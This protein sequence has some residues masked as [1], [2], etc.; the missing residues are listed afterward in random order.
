MG[1]TAAYIGNRAFALS[2][3]LTRI[4]SMPCFACLLVPLSM[5]TMILY[6][7]AHVKARECVQS[8]LSIV[9]LHV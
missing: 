8:F 9:V 6:M 7:H 2:A 4:L 1:S 5:F 3:C